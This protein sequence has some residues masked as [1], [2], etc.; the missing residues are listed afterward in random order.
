MTKVEAGNVLFCRKLGTCLDLPYTASSRWRGYFSGE[1]LTA[2]KN[3]KPAG[4]SHAH[5]ARD[6]KTKIELN[7]SLP[8]PLMTPSHTSGCWRR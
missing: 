1:L 5:T 2:K 8:F 7:V 4:T 3:S 6:V